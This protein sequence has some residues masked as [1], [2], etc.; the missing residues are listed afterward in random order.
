VADLA[1]VV[2]VGLDAGLDLPRAVLAAS[3]TPTVTD[4]APWLHRRV[5]AA[6]DGGR[7][8]ASCLADSLQPRD[9]PPRR[10]GPPPRVGR[11]PAGAGLEV[12]ARAWRLSEEAGAAAS[13]TTSAAAAALRSRAA[14]RRR[15]ATLV[16]GPRASMWLLTALPVLGPVLGLLAGVGPGRLYESQLARASAVAGVVLAAL[17]WLW[18]ARLLRRA[19]QA[20]TVSGRSG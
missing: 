5:A 10:D 18:A 3:R 19:Q 12:L 17:G 9:G 15:A 4:R 2:A 20:G 13:A 8:V 6:V 1:E 7:G 11:R 14:D 16:A